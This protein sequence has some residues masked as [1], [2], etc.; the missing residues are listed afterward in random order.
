MRSSQ[1]RM[2][3]V[4][5]VSVVLFSIFAMVTCTYAVTFPSYQSENPMAAEISLFCLQTCG[6]DLAL[7]FGDFYTSK[8]GANE[9]ERIFIDIPPGMQ[10]EITVEIFDP[11]VYNQREKSDDVFLND[12]V[13][14]P[15]ETTY[16]LLGPDG[17]TTIETKKY[18][19]SAETDSKWV[20]FNKFNTSATGSG[21]YILS[22]STSANSD[23]GWAL[24]V[25]TAAPVVG[26][27]VRLSSNQ[28][29]YFCGPK[30]Q[31]ATRLW[32]VYIP[33]DAT[34]VQFTNFDVSKNGIIEYLEPEGAAWV[35]GTSSLDGTWN[36][37][38]GCK[39]RPS[40]DQGD[41]FQKP[42]SGWW[43]IRIS[44]VDAANKFIIEASYGI[45]G[46]ACNSNRLNLFDNIE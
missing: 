22:A 3:A 16:T 40:A 42:K 44:N 17:T 23:N 38:G 13:R 27:P 28:V 2:A 8:L 5:I 21:R 11:E 7:V 39:T 37:C 46:S 36:K 15:S 31:D 32:Y 12:V 33:P 6:P 25:T 1:V 29:T 10:Q 24:K 18:S 9:N 14:N 26:E 41:I 20:I 4:Q 43:T 45:E 34:C 35:P 19:S 30:S